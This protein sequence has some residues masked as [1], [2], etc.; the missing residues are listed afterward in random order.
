MLT[1]IAY[2]D[3]CWSLLVISLD[4]QCLKRQI[5]RTI[6]GEMPWLVFPDCLVGFYIEDYIG[7]FPTL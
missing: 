7:A 4:G 6:Y 1:L 3:N 2:K 5:V